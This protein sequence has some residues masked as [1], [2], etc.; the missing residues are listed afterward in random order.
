[1]GSLHPQEDY[2]HQHTETTH[3]DET[4]NKLAVIQL[5]KVLTIL[6]CQPY[7]LYIMHK[8]KSSQEDLDT[9]SFLI[10]LL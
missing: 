4:A 7:K 6:Y 8:T 10:M 9:C 5:L 2:K 1:M 3:T